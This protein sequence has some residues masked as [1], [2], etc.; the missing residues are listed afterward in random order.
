MRSELDHLVVAART[1]DEGV[2]WVEARLGVMPQA[3]GQHVT[4]GT[5]NALLKLGPRVYL[6]VIAVD[7][8][9]P[10]PARPRWFGL[11]EPATQARL[12]RSPALIHW[13]VRCDELDA[14]VAALP[15][16]GSLLALSRGAFRWRIA[17]PPDGSLPWEGMLPTLIDWVPGEGGAVRHPCDALPDAGCA[18]LSLQVSHPAADLGTAGLVDQLRRLRLTGRVHLLNGPAGLAARIAAPRGEVVLD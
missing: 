18:L 5:H 8:T 11:D 13:V 12:T 16:T 14:A 2:R 6:E 10:A 4:M 9:L 1:L 17:V 3:G 15:E 7:P